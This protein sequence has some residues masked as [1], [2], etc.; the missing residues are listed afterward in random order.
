M[1]I[2]Q[3]LIILR[4]IPHGFYEHQMRAYFSQFGDITNLRLSRNRKTGA[5]KHFAFLEFAS[6]EVAKIA[7]SSMDNYLLFGHILK[8]KF[9]PQENVHPDTWKGANR[10]YKATPWNKLEKQ[11][12]E[13]PKTTDQWNAKIA[14]EQ[15]KRENKQKKMKELGYEF[16]VPKLKSAEDVEMPDST[17]EAP[18]PI[19]AIDPV[20]TTPA[21]EVPTTKRSKKDKKS[22]AK[23]QQKESATQAEATTAPVTSEIATS[24]A[25]T[26]PEAA[27][28]TTTEKP[29]TKKQKQHDARADS[30]TA[31]LETMNSDP[32]LAKAS[33]ALAAS[34]KEV[35]KK[36]KQ[37]NDKEAKKQAKYLASKEQGGSGG[38]K[39][40]KR[41]E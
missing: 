26:V 22:K 34:L 8:C 17:I 41:K 6:S 30:R 9:V 29:K 15:K 24:T 2:G 19:L 40:K 35:N 5:S 12:L 20:P 27:T 32:V 31:A 28:T 7:A 39:Q 13:Q 21:V 3:L 33:P 37:I 11:K 23:D 10:R 14:R 18:E 36:A 25:T 4:R 16:Q 1:D 38:M